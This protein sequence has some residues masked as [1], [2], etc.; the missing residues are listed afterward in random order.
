[1]SPPNNLCIYLPCMPHAPTHLI[2]LHFIIITILAS[3]TSHK[4][5]HMMQLSTFSFC[6][7]SLKSKYCWIC[8]NKNICYN[9]R[10]GLLLSDVARTVHDVSGLRTFIRASVIRF[11]I[12]CK[13]QLSVNVSY[14][15]SRAFSSG[16][17]F[18]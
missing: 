7:L 2:H 12:V 18:C 17:I 13:V 3:S 6:F 1:M 11:V 8:Y 9:E 16:N 5:H 14:L 4:S 10:R 15:L